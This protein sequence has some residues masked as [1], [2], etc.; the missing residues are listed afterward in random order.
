M[1]ETAAIDRIM[2][3]GRRNITPAS[4]Q[5][6]ALD[7]LYVDHIDVQK[8]RLLALNT[9]ADIQNVIKMPYMSLFSC[10]TAKR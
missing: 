9:N 2:M 1:D 7:Q 3:K 6:K 5:E 8:T 4:L 10:D